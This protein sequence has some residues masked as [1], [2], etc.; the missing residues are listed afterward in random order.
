MSHWVKTINGALN[1]IEPYVLILIHGR[2]EFLLH[3]GCSFIAPETFV[4][5]HLRVNFV[6]DFFLWK[7]IRPLLTNSKMYVDCIAQIISNSSR[8]LLRKKVKGR[9]S[10]GDTLMK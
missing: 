10:I 2:G 9:K 8:N 5:L 6:S 7:R 3:A 4:R 1:T